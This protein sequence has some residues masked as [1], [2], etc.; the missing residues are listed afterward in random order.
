MRTSQSPEGFA[1]LQE[2]ISREGPER[3]K[4]GGG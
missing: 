1:G 4:T 3:I 2:D